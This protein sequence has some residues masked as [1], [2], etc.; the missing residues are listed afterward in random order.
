VTA[1]RELV[2]PVVEE[3]STK[4]RLDAKRMPGAHPVPLTCTEVPGGPDV[5]D[6]LKV[7]TAAPATVACRNAPAVSISATATAKVRRRRG[8]F[9]GVSLTSATSCLGCHSRR[10]LAVRAIAIYRTAAENG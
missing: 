9:V 4:S 7:W 5:G 3:T 8:G 2:G 6:M 10:A 1:K